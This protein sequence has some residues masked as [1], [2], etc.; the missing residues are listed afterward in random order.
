VIEAGSVKIVAIIFC[1]EIV[2]KDIEKE[3]GHCD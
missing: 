1:P 2:H 3:M